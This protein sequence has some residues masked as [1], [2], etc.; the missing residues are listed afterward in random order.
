[1]RR[2]VFLSVYRLSCGRTSESGSKLLFTTLVLLGAEHLQHTDTPAMN[3]IPKKGEK[4]KTSTLGITRDQTGFLY[5]HNK[6]ARLG[7]LHT[8]FLDTTIC[9]TRGRVIDGNGKLLHLW[10]G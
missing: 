2:F 8:S 10:L 6:L 4:E 3:R 7:F 1:M 9:R 5:N